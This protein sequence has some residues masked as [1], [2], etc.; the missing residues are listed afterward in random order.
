VIGLNNARSNLR[1]VTRLENSRNRKKHRPGFKGVSYHAPGNKSP[2]W[3]ARITVR[4]HGLPSRTILL[5]YFMTDEDAARAYDAAAIKHHGDSAVLNFP[6][7]GGI[8]R[9][10]GVILGRPDLSAEER[11]ALRA[12]GGAP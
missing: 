8:R 4:E 3:R 7:N 5:G 10:P 2:R 9:A 1:V 11:I 12:N 6:E